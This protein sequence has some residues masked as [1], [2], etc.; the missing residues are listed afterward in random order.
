MKYAIYCEYC[1]DKIKVFS[2]QE[3]LRNL[4]TT[5]KRELVCHH[6]HEDLVDSVGENKL[7]KL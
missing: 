4:K 1:D 6:C 7:L 2:S 5:T 3:H